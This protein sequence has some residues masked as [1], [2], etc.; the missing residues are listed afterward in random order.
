VTIP[1]FLGKGTWTGTCIIGVPDAVDGATWVG[2]GGDLQSPPML[3]PVRVDNMVTGIGPGNDIQRRSVVE[4]PS[5]LHVVPESSSHGRGT[6]LS[7]SVI[8]FLAIAVNDIVVV[9]VAFNS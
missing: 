1:V 5:L 2:L 4:L 8:V 9:L 6:G 3:H 7:P